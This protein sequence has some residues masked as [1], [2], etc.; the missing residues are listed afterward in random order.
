MSVELW[1]DA[2]DT[3]EKGNR[4][5]RHGA[6]PLVRYITA[7][8]DERNAVGVVV[9]DLELAYVVVSRCLLP[10]APIQNGILE[11][12]LLMLA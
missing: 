11:L 12:T 1:R 6:P 2:L 8:K 7:S 3:L 5:G 9:C 4:R 10:D